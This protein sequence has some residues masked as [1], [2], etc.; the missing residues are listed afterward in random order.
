M[1][2]GKLKIMIKSAIIHLFSLIKEIDRK[3]I[4]Y[5]IIFI[6]FNIAFTYSLYLKERESITNNID[7]KLISVANSVKIIL[8]EDFHEI[9]INKNSI[10]KEVDKI[11]IHK[12]SRL[13]EEFGVEHVYT[14]I[15]DNDNL[16]LTASSATERELI[17]GTERKYFDRFNTNN[18]EILT[19][20]LTNEDIFVKE[21]KN[22]F[23]IFRSV[24]I[25]NKTSSGKIYVTGVDIRLDE[26]ESNIKNNEIKSFLDFSYYFI[27]IMSII[28]PLFYMLYVNIHKRANFD[29]L[30]G[31]P[32][33][34]EFNTKAELALSL[35]K[36]KNDTLSILFLDLDG[37]KSVNDTY[38]HEYGDKLLKEVAN[39]IISSIRSTDIPSRQGGDEFLI[40]L[41]NTDKATSSIIA[42][43]LVTEIRKPYT[44]NKKEIIIGVSIGIASYPSDDIKL[45]EL[46]LKSDIAMYKAK[47]N[48]KNC[49]FHYE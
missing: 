29:F 44:I 40:A 31:L 42:S 24:F 36:R 17:D 5:F 16:Y 43:K 37:F 1:N 41:L 2:K 15:K 45:K 10:S 35:S 28:M 32:N 39:R 3:N 18:K 13:A 6:I 12:L 25:Q 38:G 34:I 14:F 49:Y 20:F 21:N 4:M 46:C 47:E 23:G 30:T 8:P 19:S 22:K 11:N 9:T 48:G 7:S 33:K 26:I 27:L